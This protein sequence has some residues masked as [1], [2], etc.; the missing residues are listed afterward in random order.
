MPTPILSL[1]EVERLKRLY[2]QNERLIASIRSRYYE[3]IY[4][5]QM[6]NYRRMG[7]STRDNSLEVPTSSSQAAT[8]NVSNM[9]QQYISANPPIAAH[10]KVSDATVIMIISQ[11]NSTINLMMGSTTHH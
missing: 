8:G 5:I 6:R 3:V 1:D 10:Y 11:T 2:P 7:I 4:P 9:E